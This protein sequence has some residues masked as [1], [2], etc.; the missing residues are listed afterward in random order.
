MECAAQI[1]AHFLQASAH[2]LQ[3]SWW[4]ACLE[5]SFEQAAQISAH[6]ACKL[7]SNCEPLASKR[8]HK[9]QISAQSRHNMIHSLF[10]DATQ[11]VKQVS[12]VMTQAKQASMQFFEI[13][14]M[15]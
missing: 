10:P 15:S 11:S 13:S 12:H 6:K 3:D 8:A 7:A 4:A 5:H 1:S 9:A 14:M 2:A